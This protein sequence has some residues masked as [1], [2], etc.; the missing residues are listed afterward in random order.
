MDDTSICLPHE[1]LPWF[2]RRFEELGKPL[3]VELSKHKTYILTTTT[4]TSPTSL[5]SNTKKESLITALSFLNPTDPRQHEITGG[6]RFLG[7]PIGSP[8]FA[9][10]F[11]ALRL[12]KMSQKISMLEDLPDLQ[13]RSHLFRYSLVPSILHLLPVDMVLAHPDSQSAATVWESPAT[14]HT[15]RLV[16]QFL[17]QLT[18]TPHDKITETATLIASVTNRLGGLGYHN[19]SSAARPRLITQTARTLKLAVST[20][21]PVPGPHKTFWEDWQHS[22]LPWLTTFRRSLALY[23]KEYAGGHLTDPRRFDHT[24]HRGLLHHTITE[25]TIP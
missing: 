2:L 10:Q 19:A 4:G 13:T 3:G 18:S 25:H 6:T 17:A 21:T 1:D 23:A 9:R 5:L 16:K 24:T 8:N 11:I 15:H 14:K 20:E 12:E 22:E 7:Q